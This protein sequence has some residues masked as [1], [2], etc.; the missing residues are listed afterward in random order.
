MAGR[1]PSVQV[2]LQKKNQ[3]VPRPTGRIA[4]SHAGASTVQ[5][6]LRLIRILSVFMFAIGLMAATF[7]ANCSITPEQMSRAARS[8]D[9]IALQHALDQGLSIDSRNADGLTPLMESARAGNLSAARFLLN[10]GANVESRAR[11]LSMDSPLAIAARTSQ[12]RIVEL[13]LVH[14]ANPNAANE[15]GVTPLIFAACSSDGAADMIRELIDAGADPTAVSNTGWTAMAAARD[16]GDPVVV[17][18]IREAEELTSES[19][20]Q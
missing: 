20:S 5:H 8:G 14:H 9:L 12:P 17:E 15:A 16:S 2:H 10:H 18:M 1:R 6:C 7:L 11:D 19:V 3:S 13:L 4:V